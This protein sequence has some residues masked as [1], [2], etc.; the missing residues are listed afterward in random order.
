MPSAKAKSVNKHRSEAG[1]VSSIA[2]RSTRAKRSALDA[3]EFK[4]GALSPDHGSGRCKVPSRC[5]RGR[6]VVGGNASPASSRLNVASDSETIPSP[7]C[8]LTLR[9][10]PLANRAL[11]SPTVRRS[12][13]PRLADYDQSRYATR[14]NRKGGS[15]G[16]QVI[17]SPSASRRSPH[18]RPGVLPP[19]V[20]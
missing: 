4:A 12:T 13:R 11:I 1:T 16:Y 19:V 10:G 5:A 7:P 8:E 14:V 9:W 15:G 17:G 20:A 18:F 3:P 2:Y 6:R